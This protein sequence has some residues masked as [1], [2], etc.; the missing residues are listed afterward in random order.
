[1]RPVRAAGRRRRHRSPAARPTCPGRPRDPSLS[2][3]PGCTRASFGT[4]RPRRNATA[5]MSARCWSKQA[6]A[7]WSADRKT[8]SSTSR[9]TWSPRRNQR[10]DPHHDRR[11]EDDM[12]V[13]GFKA[14][15]LMPTWLGTTPH[16][17]RVF[18]AEDEAR[19]G[20]FATQH[21]KR[22]GA[23]ST[24]RGEAAWV[25]RCS[26]RCP[27]PE[28]RHASARPAGQPSG[29]SLRAIPCP[30]VFRSTE[31]SPGPCL[32]R[33]VPSSPDDRALDPPGTILALNEETT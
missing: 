3:T 17:V 2:G 16:R 26:G 20:P 23:S 14:A 21:A 8:C 33:P 4:P 30:T 28:P 5:S 7:P 25:G 18:M 27:F 12:G 9:S 13:T 10:P 24:A 15:P 11:F 1:V 32:R 19:W 31:Q 29:K 6:A 22:V